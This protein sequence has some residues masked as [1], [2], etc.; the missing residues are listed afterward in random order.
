MIIEAL[1]PDVT[2][3]LAPRGQAKEEAGELPL[4]FRVE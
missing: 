4:V 2:V 3:S 1:C